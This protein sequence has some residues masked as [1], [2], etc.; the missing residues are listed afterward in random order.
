MGEI[1]I[2]PTKCAGDS[3]CVEKCPMNVL[4]M[5]M[6]GKK[7]QVRVANPDACIE[8]HTCEL[9]CPYG[10]I[11]VFP[12]LGDEFE[13]MESPSTSS[14]K[15]TTAVQTGF[16]HEIPQLINFKPQQTA[17]ALWDIL[18]GYGFEVME[19]VAGINIAQ[20]MVERNQKLKEQ[21]MG[22]MRGDRR[23]FCS[24]KAIAMIHLP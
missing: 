9:E 6:A 14:G 15:P 1:K 11:K 18:Q 2:D 16:N 4:E 7:K 24:D 19:E 3:I 21:G 5:V 20:H 12:P 8:C 17:K 22:P 13:D 23:Y 10:A